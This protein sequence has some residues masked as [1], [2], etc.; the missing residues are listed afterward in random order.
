[1]K[2]LIR[3]NKDQP[4]I[5][6][7]YKR[8]ILTKTSILLIA[9]FFTIIFVLVL[10]AVSRTY[11]VKDEGEFYATANEIVYSNVEIGS[12]GPNYFFPNAEV[13]SVFESR[14][15]DMLE[16]VSVWMSLDNSTWVKVPFSSGNQDVIIGTTSLNGFPTTIYQKV[17]CPDVNV[18]V[19][20]QSIQ[21]IDLFYSSNYTIYF[22]SIFT[23]QSLVLLLLVGVAIFSFIV[24]ILDFLAKEK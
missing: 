22:T 19:Q 18:S 12:T 15:P 14:Y 7:L 1:M 6:A 24:Q 9:Y 16:N 10:L 8:K 11:I 23:S 17:Y 3:K 21:V 4:V 5:Q 2:Y 20:N 13:H